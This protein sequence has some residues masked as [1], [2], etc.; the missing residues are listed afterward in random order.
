MQMFKLL[1]LGIIISTAL[2]HMLTPSM[3]LFQ[4]DCFPLILPKYSSWTGVFCLLGILIAHLLSMFA[5]SHLEEEEMPLLEGHD[6]QNNSLLYSLEIGI[7]LHSI[8][9]GITL[10]TS[11]TEMVPLLIAISFHQFAEGVALASVI[12]ES[13]LE[14]AQAFGFLA[15]YSASTPVGIAIGISL[16][17]GVSKH[18]GIAFAVQA[19]LDAVAA[20]ILL[21]NGFVNLLAP[22]FSSFS[23]HKSTIRH[24]MIDIGCVSLG[25]IIM[26]VIG[27][28]A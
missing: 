4:S 25:C 1:G 11:T 26:A 2:I 15:F 10:G 28:W 18:V 16:R 24:K 19:I 7:A 23:Y 5:C 8:L 20:G 17:E 27:I 6:P 9:I 12:F 14:Q 13:N 3:F 21:Y 22:H